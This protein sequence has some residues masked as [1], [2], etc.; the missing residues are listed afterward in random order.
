[1]FLSFK[2]LKSF[3]DTLQDVHAAVLAISAALIFSP[4]PDSACSCLHCDVPDLWSHPV[5]V[6]L[7]PNVCT[8]S[9][10]ISRLVCFYSPSCC[11]VRSYP[12]VMHVFT[13]VCIFRCCLLAFRLEPVCL[14]SLSEEFRAV[15]QL[16]FIWNW[17]FYLWVNESRYFGYYST[18]SIVKN[19]LK[20]VESWL[21]PSD[22]LCNYL[23]LY[24]FNSLSLQALILCHYLNQI[25]VRNKVSDNIPP[26]WFAPC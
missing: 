2:K 8:C 13:C 26:H 5:T 6:C 21:D 1:M 24:F 10:F 7:L 15:H 25:C 3:L 18:S 12:F 23:F 9:V 14:F 20:G 22:F 19:A 17:C 11:F 16:V 4:W